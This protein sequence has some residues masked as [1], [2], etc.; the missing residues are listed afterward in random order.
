YNQQQDFGQGMSRYECASD[1]SHHHHI[2]CLSCGRVWEFSSATL[3]R[4][5]RQLAKEHDFEVA[6]HNLQFYGYCKDCR[7]KAREHSTT[8]PARR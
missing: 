1:D 3:E 2:V 6:G 4:V 8:T 7:L 5:E